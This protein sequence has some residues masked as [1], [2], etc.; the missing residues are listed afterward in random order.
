MSIELR[1]WERPVPA[2]LPAYTMAL[3]YLRHP[4]P[5]ARYVYTQSKRGV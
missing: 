3:L 2:K 5:I 4:H 1:V